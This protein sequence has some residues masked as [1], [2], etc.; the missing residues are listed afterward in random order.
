MVQVLAMLPPFIVPAADT[1]V[2]RSAAWIPSGE[3]LLGHPLRNTT[4][5]PSSS[6]PTPADAAPGAVTPNRQRRYGTMSDPYSS[7]Y[8]RTSVQSSLI[9]PVKPLQP[10]R[11]LS[12]VA[13]HVLLLRTLCSSCGQR[14]V[15]KTAGATL[16]RGTPSPHACRSWS[17]SPYGVA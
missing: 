7:G 14:T 3:C 9:Q 13:I 15:P 6:H 10:A 5:R 12:L 8:H 11:L 16:A 4:L 17:G 1:P 2:C